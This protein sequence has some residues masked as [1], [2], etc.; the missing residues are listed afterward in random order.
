[1][2]LVLAILIAL[3]CGAQLLLLGSSTPSMEL[4]STFCSVTVYFFDVGQGDSILINV[5]DKNILIDG[6]SK[7]A[8]ATLLGYLDGVNVTHIDVM[9]ATH[10][11]EDHIGGL[12]TVMQSTITIDL[13]LYNGQNYTSKAFEDF[14]SLG[15]EHN[16]TVTDRSQ[17]YLVTAT[18]NFTILNPVQPL[19]FADTNANANSIVIKLQVSNVSFLF[20]GDATAETEQS[21]INAGLNLQSDVLKVAH[22]GSNTS[23]TQAFLDAVNPTYAVIS[24]GLGNPYG[25]PHEEVVQRLL[26]KGIIVYGTYASGTIV[27]VTDGNTVTVQGNPEPI[28]EFHSTILLPV[29]LLTTLTAMFLL[30]KKND[31]NEI[32]HLT[33]LIF[34][35]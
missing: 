33:A 10:P 15:Q 8:G 13:I 24:A 22:H 3:S 6:G 20:S 32:L 1:M 31:P 34:L 14:M 28:P 23:T 19:E 35:F 16:L 29:L 7:S 26:D 11:H 30:K 2:A 21:M 12:I 25:H 17:V 4:A 18:T 9:V 5:D 27:F